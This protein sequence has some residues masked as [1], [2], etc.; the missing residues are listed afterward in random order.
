MLLNYQ[1]MNKKFIYI[2]FIKNIFIIFFEIF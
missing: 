2:S 1:F